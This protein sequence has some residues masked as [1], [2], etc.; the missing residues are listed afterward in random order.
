MPVTVEIDAAAKIVYSRFTG[1]LNDAGFRAAVADLAKHPGFDTAFSHIIDFSGVSAYKI[2]AN[3]TRAF[4]Q[5]KP[6]FKRE[7]KQI[8]VAPQ[9]HVFGM[10]RMAQ[11]LRERQLPNIQVVRSLAEAYAILGVKHPARVLSR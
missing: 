3:F 9:T 7:A 2:S 1:I 11:I 4:A 6:L 8:I 5:E 10:A